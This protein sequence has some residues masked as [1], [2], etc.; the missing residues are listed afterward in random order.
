LQII[1]KLC[2]LYLNQGER[3]GSSIPIA[4]YVAGE[5]DIERLPS[6]TTI[7]R[8]GMMRRIFFL[9]LVLAVTVSMLLC[10]TPVLRAQ[11]SGS[12]DEPAAFEE[13]SAEEEAGE[14]A[15]EE[16]A[17]VSQAASPAEPAPVKTPAVEVSRMA[18]CTNIVD[19][20][21]VEE[22]E[23]FNAS[24]G[25]LYAFTHIMGANDFVEL[26]HVWYFNDVERA[27]ITLPVR[28][29][30][31]RTYSS[32]LIQPFEIGDWRVDVVDPQG[33]VLK[34]VAFQVIK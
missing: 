32:K 7:K 3:D 10:H 13:P 33:E 14:V 8:R 28:S 29:P 17:P 2:R 24:V 16:A 26:G 19:R 30:N 6:I 21:P 31:W 23:R 15:K 34:S 4:Q 20:E 27:R 11:E 5:W 9:M 22:G 25:R 18:V 12:G 1:D